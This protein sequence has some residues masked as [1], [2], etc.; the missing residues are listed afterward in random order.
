VKRCLVCDNKYDVASKSCPDCDFKPEMIDGFEAY[1][2]EYANEGG[3]FKASYFEQLAQYE[4][5]HFWFQ[6]RNKLIQWALEKYCRNFQSFLEI[7]CGTGFVLSGIA[8]R[9][10]AAQLNGSEIFISG[11]GFAAERL[12]AVKL[13]QMDARKIPFD[14]E[15]DAIGAFDVIE[16]IEEDETV[17]SQ[18]YIALKPGGY[19]LL[20]VPQHAWLWSP[21]DD[22]AC[23]QRRYSAADLHRKVDN[24]GFS[25][26]RSTSFVTSLLPAMMASRFY[27]KKFSSA[28]FDAS[29]EYRISP[30]MNKLFSVFLNME[31]GMIRAGINFPVGGSRLL[32]AKKL[33]A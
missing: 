12:P 1:A 5:A 17:L 24:A 27:Q 15:F 20:T 21:S 9:Y 22:Y 26:L 31:L 28:E 2:S 14:N 32:V 4:A 29:A 18:L 7:G 8:Q 19:L 3:G 23:H 25:R 10:P 6:M 11:L 13:M 33:Q 30:W 16:H